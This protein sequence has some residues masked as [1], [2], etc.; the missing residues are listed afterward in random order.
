MDSS[1]FSSYEIRS[2]KV[3]VARLMASIILY[4]RSSILV[5]VDN[6][7]ASIN[8]IAFIHVLYCDIF[9]YNTRMLNILYCD[10]LDI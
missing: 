7:I 8:S 4:P 10:G 5:S 9:D 6:S 2:C 3:T 1:K